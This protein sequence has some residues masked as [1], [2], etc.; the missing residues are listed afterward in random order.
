MTERDAAPLQA[1]HDFLDKIED[2]ATDANGA[3][4]RAGLAAEH[5]AQNAL[6][7]ESVSIPGLDPV[8]QQAA[9]IARLEGELSSLVERHALMMTQMQTLQ[10]MLSI[11]HLSISAEPEQ[12]QSEPELTGLEPETEQ[13][14][15]AAD[16]LPTEAALQ[17][18]KIADEPPVQMTP[19]QK[20]KRSFRLI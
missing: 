3:A 13:P 1:V 19:E 7:A 12:T 20:R 8:E 11:P 15:N 4:E 2:A 14:R 10:K 5:A 18:E 9:H 17:P 16:L 6:H